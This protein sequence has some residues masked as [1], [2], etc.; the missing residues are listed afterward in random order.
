MGQILSD[1]PGKLR[2][3]NR[4]SSTINSIYLRNR[5]GNISHDSILPYS[6]G[7][8]R[9]VLRLERRSR[10]DSQVFISDFVMLDKYW[11]VIE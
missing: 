5:I 2:M 7:Y 9:S 4:W 1:A 8:V 6:N 10:Q 3:R 11:L